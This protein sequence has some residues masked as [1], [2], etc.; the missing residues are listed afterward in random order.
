MKNKKQ[1]PKLPKLL[2]KSRNQKKKKLQ[3]K[4]NQHRDYLK[5]QDMIPCSFG[6]IVFY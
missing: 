4:V 6:A 5:E 3:Y 2:L 1:A